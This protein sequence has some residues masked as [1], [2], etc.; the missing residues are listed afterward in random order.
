VV[1]NNGILTALLGDHRRAPCSSRATRCL[2]QQQQQWT[3][4][5]MMHQSSTGHNAYSRRCRANIYLRHCGPAAGESKDSRSLGPPL[6]TLCR[7]TATGAPRPA[8]MPCYGYRSGCNTT[9]S[10]LDKGGS[11]RL[12]T[13]GDDATIGQSRQLKQKTYRRLSVLSK[14]VT[15]ALVS[16]KGREAQG[17]WG[18]C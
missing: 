18:E 3:T 4:I 16:K 11:R 8:V 15:Y 6:W 10:T 1:P 14:Y 2:L 5:M 9:G 12:P 17:W 7:T 13:N